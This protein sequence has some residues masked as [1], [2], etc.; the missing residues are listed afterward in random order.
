MT[1][2]R[3]RWLLLAVLFFSAPIALGW[4]IVLMLFITSWQ[5]YR[6]DDEKRK[7]TTPCF[8]TLLAGV[9]CALSTYW[10]SIWGWLL[11][12]A[13]LTITMMGPPLI[14][15]GVSGVNRKT[16]P[17]PAVKADLDFDK[18]DCIDAIWWNADEAPPPGI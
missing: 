7:A 15:C 17:K 12:S 1:W 11:A 9:G 18:S 2:N 13:I 6:D 10:C 16:T 14:N 4:V 5:H 3:W 8:C